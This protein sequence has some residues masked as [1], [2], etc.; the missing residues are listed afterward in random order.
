VEVADD[1]DVHPELMEAFD[2]VRNG[3]GGI[4]IVDSHA[5]QFGAG[6]GERSYLLYG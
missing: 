5:D 2:D 6:A 1:G 4:V 3:L